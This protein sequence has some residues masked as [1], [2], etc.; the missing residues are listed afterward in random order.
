MPHY[1]GVKFKVDIVVAQGVAQT[2]PPVVIM[3]SIMQF[4]WL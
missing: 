1:Q 3:Q 4:E 2:G